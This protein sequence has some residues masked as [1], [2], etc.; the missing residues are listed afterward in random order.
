MPSSS[1]LSTAS[2]CL[3]KGLLCYRPV[4]FRPVFLAPN[5]D[6]PRNVQNAD[7]EGGPAK[8]DLNAATISSKLSPDWTKMNWCHPWDSNP[9]PADYEQICSTDLRTVDRRVRSICP[10]G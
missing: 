4:R 2:R 9:W 5:R 6:A 7:P 8:K 3:R 1:P 10:L